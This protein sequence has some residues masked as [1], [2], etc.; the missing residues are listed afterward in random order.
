MVDLFEENVRN[1][2]TCNTCTNSNNKC[3]WRLYYRLRGNKSRRMSGRIPVTNANTIVPEKADDIMCLRV[4][5]PISISPNKCC[6]LAH[7]VSQRTR[8]IF[9]EFSKY[10]LNSF[11][12]LLFTSKC[13]T[14]KTR[15]LCFMV[16][17][18]WRKRI[19]IENI[20]TEML[21][22]S[23]LRFVLNQC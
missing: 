15:V 11:L 9:V 6:D 8:W 23:L 19:H 12:S 10:P 4:N 1:N 3:E 18:I 22:I 17:N 21:G 7:A 2:L 16:P 14:K 20:C 5:T 13:P